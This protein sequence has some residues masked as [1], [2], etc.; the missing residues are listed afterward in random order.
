[1]SNNFGHVQK[2]TRE[3]GG[4]IITFRSKGEYHW[5]VW[6][7]LRKEQGIIIDW[8][9]ENEKLE[10]ITK[11]GDRKYYRPDFTIQTSEKDS[12]LGLEDEYEFEEFKGYFPAK[13]ATKI[14]LAA[15]Q[16]E[17]PVTLIFA[18]LTSNSRNSKTRAQFNRAKR[19]E[20]YLKRVIY[21]ANKDI[22]QSIRHLFE[23]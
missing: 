17:N 23:T 19:L 6:C 4:R 14:R 7:E 9:Y 18:N 3:V 12:L 21:N 8:W 20:P 15:Q 16:Y 10:L 5:C 22:F 2:L 13:D 11:C 1:M